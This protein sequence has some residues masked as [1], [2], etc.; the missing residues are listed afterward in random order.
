M[1]PSEPADELAHI[2]TQQTRPDRWQNPV[3][4]GRYQLVVIGGGPAGLVCAAGAASLGAKVALIE[5]GR[6]GGD[7]LH[8]GCVPSKAL[9][10][11]A[12]AITACHRASE[13]G[14]VTP[15]RASV[16]FPAVMERVRRLRAQL[17][18]ADSARRFKELGVDVFF[19]MARFINPDQLQVGETR[20]QFRRAVIAT[21]ANPAKPLIPGLADDVYLTNESIFHLTHR[22]HRLIVLGAGPVGCELA[23]A[24]ARLGTQV[25]MLSR[26]QAVLAREEPV[27]SDLVL[28]SLKKD[29][30]T[31]H[32]GVVITRG[33]LLGSTFV[34]H[35]STG[36]PIEGDALLAAVGRTPNVAGLNLEAAGVALDGGRI[37]VDDF[38]RTT[39][40]RIYA[41]GDVCSARQFTHAA[42]AMARIVVRNALFLGRQ[43]W[44]RAVIPHC[45]YTDPEVASVGL[46][47][48]D[49]KRRGLEIQTI[50]ATFQEL[51]R[52]VLDGQ[53][54]GLAMVH[55]RK[56]TDRIVGATIVASHAADLLAEFTSAMTL[57][58]GM[59][60]LSKVVRPYPTRAEIVKKLADAYQRSRLTPR[61]AGI[62]RWFLRQTR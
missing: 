53:P 62:L 9:I 55:L 32:P 52:A 31:Y 49:A 46:T 56:G 50:E 42:D 2:L 34:L 23:Q 51:D 4:A 10:A 36:V 14:I 16:D 58:I 25:I 57:G 30:V 15:I 13:Y 33:E 59:G 17:S 12:Q 27:A 41:A 19:G 45:T 5:R 26:S 22:P 54:H 44:S 18:S 20:L 43:R 1:I 3:P 39:N 48:V 24:F 38:L 61:N 6:L 35:S 28:T 37:Q 7:C 8:F 29:G 40:P 11:S 47:S 60:S 21:G